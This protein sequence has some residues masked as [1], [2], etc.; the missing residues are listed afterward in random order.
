MH[1]DPLRDRP[2]VQR[3]GLQGP[4]DQEVEGAGKN[5]GYWSTAH[6]VGYD[7]SAVGVGCQQQ[8]AGRWT[9]LH[10]KTVEQRA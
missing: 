1:L 5:V 3:L 4:Q 6:C 2:A 9:P 7:S 8:R 10:S